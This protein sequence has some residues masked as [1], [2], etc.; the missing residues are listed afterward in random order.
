MQVQCF[1]QVLREKMA[2]LCN[3]AFASLKYC[4]KEKQP[5]VGFSE[6]KH[7]TDLRKLPSHFKQ[8]PEFLTVCNQ[9]LL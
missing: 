9:V 2:T 1:T 5:N 7:A 6:Q 8:L 3:D 4:E